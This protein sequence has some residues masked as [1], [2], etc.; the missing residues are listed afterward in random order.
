MLLS[1]CS[2]NL[3]STLTQLSRSPLLKREAQ[4]AR[5]A[6][7]SRRE[8]CVTDIHKAAHLLDPRFQGMHLTEDEVVNASEFIFDTAKQMHV[9]HSQA[10]TDLAEYCAKH[11]LW[12]KSSSGH[13]L[14]MCYHMCGGLCMITFILPN[15]TD[16]QTK[17]LESWFMS[18]TIS[19]ILMIMISCQLTTR[20]TGA[21]DEGDAC[22]IHGTSTSTTDIADNHDVM[23]FCA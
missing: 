21:S 18:I 4:A 14:N 10:M 15:K 9:D 3:H 19:S 12:A 22:H 7:N 13:L 2:L 11:G 23:A 1:K 5:A 20:S 16:C 6:L 17:L 8:F